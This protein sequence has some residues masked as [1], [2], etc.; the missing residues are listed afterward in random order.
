MNKGSR[1]KRKIGP[2]LWNRYRS[3]FELRLKKKPKN[4]T[5]LKG[6]IYAQ[7]K[8]KLTGRQTDKLTADHFRALTE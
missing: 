1:K 7:D 6:K 5:G 2:G 8:R 3:L 4:Y